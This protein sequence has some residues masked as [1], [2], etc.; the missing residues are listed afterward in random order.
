V[1][2]APRT[3]E[4][5]GTYHVTA[6]GLDDRPIFVD[7][8]DRQTFVLRLDRVVQRFAW[9]V[10]AVCLMTTHFHLLIRL[11]EP[12]LA[13]GMQIVTGAHAR[14]FNTRHR[15]RGALFEA[16]YDDTHV[17]DDSHLLSAIR[18][19]ALNPVEAGIVARPQDW[20]WSTYRQLI[21]EDRPWPFFDPVFV[22]EHFSERPIAAVRLVREFVEGAGQV[23]DTEGVR[24]EGA[25]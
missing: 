5:D 4:A 21:L 13:A 20:P 6:H 15:R 22:L 1:P 24:H 8:F 10:Y 7:D 9:R 3:H 23:P 11:S 18:Y 2:R 16:R 19:V 25:V 17:V 14:T 12:N